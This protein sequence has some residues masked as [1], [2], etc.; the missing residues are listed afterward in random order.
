MNEAPTTISFSELHNRIAKLP[1]QSAD[2]TP[3]GERRALWWVTSATAVGLLVGAFGRALIPSWLLS[4]LLIT[5]LL[6][7]CGA[8]LLYAFFMLRRELPNIRH[9]KRNHARELDLEFAE[10]RSIVDWLRQSPVSVREARLQFSTALAARIN[11]RLGLLLG[12]I[13]RLGAMPWLI[14]FYLQM[15]DWRFGDWAS[16]FDVSALSAVLI[17]AI[18]ILYLVGWFAVN[19]RLRIEL[20]ADLL[21]ASLIAASENQCEASARQS[22]NRRRRAS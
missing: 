5:A 22:P 2:A 1:K 14:A 16:L 20:Y 11:V 8:F 13:E 18:L 15:K 4:P 6:T 12:G 21:S 9:A 19:L 3:A 10:Y 7:Q 17:F